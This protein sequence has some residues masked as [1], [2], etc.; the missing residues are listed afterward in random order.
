MAASTIMLTDWLKIQK[1]SSPKTT[2]VI[3]LLPDR[4]VPY[5]IWPFENFKVFLLIRN[6]R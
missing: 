5:N 6:P 3:K 2:Y 4:N 1:S